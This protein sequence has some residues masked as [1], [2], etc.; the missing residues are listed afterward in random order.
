MNPYTID[1]SAIARKGRKDKRSPLSVFIKT[2]ATRVPINKEQATNEPRDF[3]DE[4][5]LNFITF[6]SY[7]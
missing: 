1:I 7:P 4:T 3:R 2:N 6:L 5:L